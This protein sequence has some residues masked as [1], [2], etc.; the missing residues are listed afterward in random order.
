MDCF[1]FASPMIRKIQTN[2]IAWFNLANP[3]IVEMEKFAREYKFHPLDVESVMTPLTRSRFEDYDHYLYAVFLF[4]LYDRKNRVIRPA[5][6]DCFVGK[7]FLIT[8]HHNKFQP[9]VDFFGIMSVSSDFQK[10]YFRS[11]ESLLYELFNKLLTSI[12]PMLD[13]MNQELADIE[14]GVLSGRERQMVDEISVVRR[15][16]INFRQIMQAHKNIFKRFVLTCRNP[17]LLYINDHVY[18][19]RLITYTKEIW[20]ILDNFRDRITGL[21]ETNDSLISYKINDVMRRLTIISV[22]ILPA[23]LIATLFGTNFISIPLQ[24]HPFGFWVLLFFLILGVSG[25]AFYFKQKKWL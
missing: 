24:N 5:K 9:L 13:H 12:F 1:I 11:M 4:P 23:S 15:K 8:I 18:F 2:G 10:K 19:D 6:I 21:Q 22:L 3:S 7:D 20:D 17:H 25:L 16:V 14:K